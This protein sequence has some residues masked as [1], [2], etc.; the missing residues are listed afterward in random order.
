MD[1]NQL[2]RRGKEIDTRPIYV[3]EWLDSLPYADFVNTARLLLEALKES[4]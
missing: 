2:P 1:N 4:N 3:E